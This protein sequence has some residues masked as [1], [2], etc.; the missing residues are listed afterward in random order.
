MSKRHQPQSNK[1]FWMQ[2]VPMAEPLHFGRLRHKALLRYHRS[3]CTSSPTSGAGEQGPHRVPTW[4]AAP[5]PGWQA[6]VT[7]QHHR[8]TSSAS[9]R[10]GS[11]TKETP[12][13]CPAAPALLRKTLCQHAV[14]HCPVIPFGIYDVGR[15][16]SPVLTKFLQKCSGFSK[17]VWLTAA[18]LFSY[19]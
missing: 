13:Q 10:A 15:R 18:V 16:P 12:L 11:C 3:G 19:C 14:K 6:A 9:A 4:T 17:T 2:L 7:R 8:I 5:A 1:L